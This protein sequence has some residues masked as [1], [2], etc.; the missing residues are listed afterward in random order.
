METD[1]ATVLRAAGADA[2]VIDAESD[3]PFK[4][5]VKGKAKYEDFMDHELEQFRPFIKYKYRSGYIE[6]YSDHLIGA[7]LNRANIM[8][9]SYNMCSV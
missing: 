8:Y 1:A 6:L 4:I 5:H 3:G 9:S 2:W 7:K